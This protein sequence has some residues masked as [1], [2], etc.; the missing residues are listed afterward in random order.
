MI[1]TISFFSPFFCHV[2]AG[3][4]GALT[5]V[6]LC[7]P[8]RCPVSVQ[9]PVVVETGGFPPAHGGQHTDQ[10]LPHS[11][12][13]PLFLRYRRPS[14]SQQSDFSLFVFFSSNTRAVFPH[15]GHDDDHTAHGDQWRVDPSGHQGGGSEER[16]RRNDHHEEVVL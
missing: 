5:G 15:R 8:C 16:H 13:R 2:L 4:H 1:E 11:A 10:R 7:V 6:P 9:Q 12:Q 14:A 3:R